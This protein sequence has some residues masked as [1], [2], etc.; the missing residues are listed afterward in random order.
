VAQRDIPPAKQET[1][2]LANRFST[3]EI[4]RRISSLEELRDHLGRNIQEGLA[5]EVA[6]LSIFIV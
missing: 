3:V 2:T 6:F 4:L 1:A 5:I